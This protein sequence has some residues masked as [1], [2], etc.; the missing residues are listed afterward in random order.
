[1]VRWEPGAQDRLERAA[2]ELFGEVGFVEA[3]VPAITARAGLTTRTFFRYFADKREV[4][5][6][7]DADYVERVARLVAEAPADLAPLELIRRSLPTL[8]AQEFEGRRE[9]LRARHLI[10]ASDHGLQERDLLKQAT[11]VQTIEHGL[12]ARGT[13]PLSAALAAATSVAIFGTAIRR[14]L[15]ADDER[16]LAEHVQDALAAFAAFAAPA[17]RP[18]PTPDGG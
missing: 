12:C 10:V 4:L 7:G 17:R 16:T 8:A 5:F 6:A 14:W 3:T 11:L 13:D 2:W 9:Q 18:D 1:M 15:A